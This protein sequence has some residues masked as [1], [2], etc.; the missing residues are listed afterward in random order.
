MEF[1]QYTGEPTDEEIQSRKAHD[2][3]N[4]DMLAI[5]PECPTCGSINTMWIRQRWSVCFGCDSS[6]TLEECHEE[7]DWWRQFD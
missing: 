7:E 1:W 6:F 2:K 5:R 4:R 3:A